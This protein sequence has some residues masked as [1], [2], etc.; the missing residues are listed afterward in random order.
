MER[1]GR[2]AAD[3]NDVHDREQSGRL[4][5]DAYGYSFGEYYFPGY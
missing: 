1:H 2:H 3:R 4:V 5:R